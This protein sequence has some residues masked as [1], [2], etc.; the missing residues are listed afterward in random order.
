[1]AY[2]ISQIFDKSGP[3]ANLMPNYESRE[4]QIQMAMAV[5]NAAKTSG[6]LIV[7]AGTGIGKSFAY[8]VPIADYALEN[9]A[10]GIISTN[11]ISLQEQILNKDIPLLEKAL[12]KDFKAI[13]VKGRNNYICLRRLYRSE[14]KQQDLFADEYEIR[15]FSR[16][17]N[18]SYKTLDG[19]L[20]DFEEEPD[21]RVWEQVSSNS[22]TCFGKSCPYYKKCFF[23]TAREK[24]KDARLL[25][26][27]HHLFFS[28]L[29][30]I[31]EQKSILP[32]YDVL[33]FD[34]AHSIETVATE[35]LGASVTNTG[36][37]YQMDLLFNLR[38]QKGFL[39]SIGDQESIEIVEHIKQ[40]SEQFFKAIK[41]YFQGHSKK[42][43][44]D[45]LRIRQKCFVENILEAPFLNLIESLQN[46]KEKALNK[47]DEIEVASYIR[48]IT[49]FKNSID[50]VLSQTAENYV[51]WIECSLSKNSNKSSINAA[52]IG[53]GGIL[54]NVIFNQQ[55]PIILTSATLCVPNQRN[56]DFQY[57]RDRI[58]IIDAEELKLGSPFDYKNNVRMY[59]AQNMP[60]PDKI[61]EY[62]HASANRIK[63]YLGLTNGSAF[64]LFTSYSLMNSVFEEIQD[65][66]NDKG[67]NL[68]RQGAGLSKSTMLSRFRNE[69][70]SVLFG[71]DTFWQGIDVQGKALSNVIITKLP[72]SVPD[73]PIVEARIEEIERK[74]H[75][76]F[77]GYYLPEAILKFKQGFGR[78][79][80]S[81]TDTGIIAILD[82]RILTKPYGKLFLNS[83][84]ECDII[85]E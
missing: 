2:N 35:H 21:S 81:K 68:L 42:E 39:L 76:A 27:N 14:L 37:K 57:F 33:V 25:I 16:I 28:N 48:K 22:E 54:E 13:L 30:L 26:V 50:L 32:E 23:Q 18:W 6:K 79:I 31:E 38:K 52:P 5:E 12:N 61:T 83:V 19:S 24:I 11:T 72:F 15:Q 36:I 78:L 84:P 51:Y 56:T 66:I 20:Q 1:M 71:V 45:T 47:E 7:E 85:I 77:S 41:S 4:E 44:S 3:I 70:G 58:G 62:S 17:L 64:V 59:I 53:I 55:K 9:N 29:A 8:L 63:R 75:D 60:S 82:S 80:R 67:F 10:I 74:G 49:A 65:Y 43:G 46:A 40:C 73:H 69:I 34:E